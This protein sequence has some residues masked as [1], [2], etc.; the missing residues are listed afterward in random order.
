MANSPDLEARVA[1]L[2]ARLEE[3]AADAVAAR[4]LAAGADRDVSE[5]RAELRAPTSALNALRETQVE[6]GQAMNQGFA[7]MRGKLDQT[8]GGLE[9][10]GGLLNTLIARDTDQQ[11]R[12]PCPASDPCRDLLRLVEANRARDPRGRSA[13]REDEQTND[14]RL[15]EGQEA[16]RHWEIPRREWAAVPTAGRGAAGRLP[17][18]DAG[19]P[20][21]RPS[22]G[23]QY[24]QVCAE[25]AL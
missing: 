20:G 16:A 15:H 1:A 17:P 22:D 24:C 2:E 11:R 8:A 9:L 10:I 18:R 13:G 12:T 19:L 14:A 6:Q 23:P 21:R 5:V 3:V 7:E 4:H 25:R